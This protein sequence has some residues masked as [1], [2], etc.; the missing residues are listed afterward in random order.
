M[1]TSVQAD[2]CVSSLQCPGIGYYGISCTR[3][4]DGSSVCNCT[5][6]RSDYEVSGL[7]GVAVCDTIAVVCVSGEGWSFDGPRECSLTVER[8]EAAAC[9]LKQTCTQSLTIGDNVT[10]VNTVEYGV[11]CYDYGDGY[12]SCLCDYGP[13]FFV[14]GKDG[15]E[16]CDA[17]FGPCVA[18][19]PIEFEGEPTCTAG[20]GTGS[21]GSCT[22]IPLCER[23]LDLGNGVTAAEFNTFEI[24]CWAMLDTVQCA[25]SFEGYTAFFD[26]DAV[27]S[28]EQSCGRY[29]ELCAGHVAPVAASSE[30]E[31]VP[32]GQQ[33]TAAGCNATFDC[34]QRATFDG[35]QLV[36]SGSLVADCAPAGDGYV[37]ACSSFG[38]SVQ[39]E[40][41]ASTAWDA[42]T[43][44]RTECPNRIEPTIGDGV[45]LPP[46]PPPSD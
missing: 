36:I 32:N 45:I 33:L 8:R 46:V 25:C 15:T 43:A 13:A 22:V 2:G 41:A 30:V 38:D 19:T 18:D 11:S 21:E 7:S 9:E 6:I 39:I 4:A 3:R 14:E 5:D 20:Y 42:C 40:V 17:L 16:A 27:L 23:R 12:L 26:T 29:V 37:C 10:A 35:E 28:D 31:C 34:A 1:G 24:N 44:A